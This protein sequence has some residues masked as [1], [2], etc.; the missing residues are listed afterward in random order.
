[1]IPTTYL[2]HANEPSSEIASAQPFIVVWEFQE[3]CKRHPYLSGDDLALAVDIAN[4]FT[5]ADLRYRSLQ[6][7]LHSSV[8]LLMILGATI[9]VP[10]F[11]AVLMLVLVAQWIENDLVL[12]WLAVPLWFLFGWLIGV[13]C[14]GNRWFKTRK[15]KIDRRA[16]IY[17]GS[18]A[19][20]H[21]VLLAPYRRRVR[22]V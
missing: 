15:S 7:T 16:R 13:L 5:M 19:F 18:V 4:R 20:R 10:F 21:E 11:A 22:R 17:A 14:L 9:V 3:F 8:M 1:M 2:G 6:A 12:A